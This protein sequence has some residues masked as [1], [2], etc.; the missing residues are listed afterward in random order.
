MHLVVLKQVDQFA[1]LAIISAIRDRLVIRREFLL[2]RS[3]ERYLLGRVRSPQT[4][5]ASLT[6]RPCDRNDGGDAGFANWQT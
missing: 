5:A 2:A 1:Q 6:R 3:A 4:L